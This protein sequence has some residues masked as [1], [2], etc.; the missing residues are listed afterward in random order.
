M[1]PVRPR[2]MPSEAAERA[3]TD[4]NA[5]RLRLP[6]RTH[7]RPHRTRLERYSDDMPSVTPTSRGV[8]LASATM[9]LTYALAYVTV[10]P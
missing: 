2:W 9:S 5:R 10:S 8:C 4:S 7:R 1:K 3:L 6:L